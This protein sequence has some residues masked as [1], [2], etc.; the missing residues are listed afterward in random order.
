MKR[1]DFCRLPACV[2]VHLK[3][4]RGAK[5]FIQ[6]LVGVFA[7]CTL[8]CGCVPDRPVAQAAQDVIIVDIPKYNPLWSLKV[9]DKTILEDGRA[10]TLKL[11]KKLFESG[12][13]VFYWSLNNWNYV[14]HKIGFVLGG[15]AKLPPPPDLVQV[16]AALKFS[17]GDERTTIKVYA[18]VDSKRDMKIEFEPAC[19]I[20][21]GKYD[22]VVYKSSGERWFS[23]QYGITA[24]EGPVSIQLMPP[25]TDEIKSEIQ[26]AFNSFDQALI[27]ELCSLHGNDL[28]I[29]LMGARYKK[30][31][32]VPR[33]P[34]VP[35]SG[36]EQLKNYPNEW[37]TEVLRDESVQ[38]IQAWRGY[39]QTKDRE[40][41]IK[42]LSTLTAEYP[43]DQKMAFALWAVQTVAATNE[44]KISKPED[45]F[46]ILGD[47][48]PAKLLWTLHGFEKAY[49]RGLWGKGYFK[50][51]LKAIKQLEKSRFQYLANKNEDTGEDIGNIK[52]ICEKIVDRY[53]E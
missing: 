7:F 2:L 53:G 9:R 48:P 30:T 41:L 36:M 13:F 25:F 52:I 42:D 6:T 1:L 50:D 18:V 21:P 31:E 45:E 28:K 34:T 40:E 12:D 51:T 17:M 11:N 14:E 16:S 37:L 15:Y 35:K 4:Q 27:T 49:P 8:L 44:G 22:F 3:P 10:Q 26:T 46:D 32:K 39:D 38:W 47:Y 5:R 23:K 29:S 19:K 43:D 33:N 20:P 24:E